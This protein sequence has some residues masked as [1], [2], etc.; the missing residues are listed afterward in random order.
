[1]SKLI[2]KMTVVTGLF[3]IVACQDK[4]QESQ[5]QQ[6][7]ES[8]EQLQSTGPR[9]AYSIIQDST[10]VLWQCSKPSWTHEGRIGVSGGKAILEGSQLIE[11]EVILD[12]NSIEVT[13]LSGE[14]KLKLEAHLKG[15]KEGGEDD[16][17]NVSN[18]PEAHFNITRV[19]PLHNDEAFNSLV[20]GNL[21]I[22]EIER[23]IGFKANVVRKGHIVWMA[24]EKFAIDR[25]DWGIRFMS[26]S[27]FPRLKDEFIDDKVHLEL[28]MKATGSI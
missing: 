15:T 14:G 23:E 8:S 10:F 18:Y 2:L 21:K 7:S 28:F 17:F 12:M 5:T 25:T 1:M 11:G 4:S 26:K 19:V 20:Y 22:K 16:F 6:Q 27:F 13:D 24:S 9:I 3:F